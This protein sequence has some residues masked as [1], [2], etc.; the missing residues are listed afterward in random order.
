MLWQGTQEKGC[1]AVGPYN[2]ESRPLV[3]ATITEKSVAYIQDHANDEE[4]FFLY[5]PY[6]LVHHPAIPHPDFKGSTRGGDFADCM[7]ECDH[8]SGQVLDALDEAGIADD[9]IVVW[10]SDNGP[11]LISSLGAQADSGPWK[12]CLGTAY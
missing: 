10:A 8:R 7:V 12:G 6:S 4:P 2:M 11:I 3:D 5:I 1:E 9:T